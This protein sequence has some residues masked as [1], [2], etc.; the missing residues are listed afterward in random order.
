[1]TA[2]LRLGAPGVLH[3]PR[4][5]GRTPEA[6]RLDVAG[7]AGIA[8]RGPVDVP[9]AVE[10]WTDYRLRFGGY[11]GPGLLPFAVRA[12]FRQG[13]AR[14][15]VLRVGDTEGTAAHELPG[16]VRFTARGPGEGGNTL[17]IRL[18]FTVGRSFRAETS[19]DRLRPDDGVEA[20]PGTLL[21]VRGPGLAR[22]G[23]FRRV[24]AVEKGMALL[25]RPLP[26][27]VDAEPVTATLHVTDGDRT[28]PRTEQHAG[29]ALTPGH[30]RFIAEVVT[31]ESLLVAPEGP[32][33]GRPLDPP[34]ALLRPLVSSRVKD[35]ADRYAAI[36]RT[37]FFDAK[38][39]PDP[40]GERSHRGVD[41]LARIPDLGLLAVP[42]LRWNRGA[43][44]DARDPD[45]L[46]ELVER[47][48]RLVELA[49][50]HQ[51]FTVLLD[52]PPGFDVRA[53]GRWRTGFASAYAAAY[54]PWLGVAGPDG[55]LREVPP[56][57]FAAG[58]IAARERRLGIPWGPANEPAADAVLARDRIG[59]AEH[60]ALFELGVNVFREEH[61]G[62]RPASARTLAHDRGLRQLS[63]QRLMTMLREVLRRRTQWAVFEPATGGLRELLVGSVTG[64]VRDLYRAGALAG[65][66]EREAFF[67]RA[68][69]DLNPRA[70]VEQGRLVVEVGVAP[71]EPLEFLVLVLSREAG[72]GIRVEEA[73][74]WASTA[75]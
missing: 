48:K 26:G 9:V 6:V 17:E 42:D 23:E 21:R 54:Q 2:G 4:R 75:R 41:M 73:G 62:Y 64:V 58:I 60:D 46:G 69:D 18:V 67:V 44:L 53:V 7:F 52:V 66:S 1:V 56:S 11:E 50:R 49:E 55:S 71:A 72:D 70:S 65:N 36:D 13:G 31:A 30:P 14:A 45:G 25:D 5:D 10:S 68:G 63:V 61:D 39:D 47:Q 3:R 28:L 74:P 27:P 43:E 32:W 57:A 51:R 20:G 24:H 29:L 8:P 35:G 16:G 38:P 37:A 15:H 33:T 19:G 22:D 40:F 12:F 34:D 59:D